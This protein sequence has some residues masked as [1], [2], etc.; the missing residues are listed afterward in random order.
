MNFHCIDIGNTSTS[1]CHVKNN[2][3]GKLTR[4]LNNENSIKYF[5][6]CK[7]RNID[8]VIISSV[9]PDISNQIIDDLE[10]RN[11]DY[12]NISYKNSVVEL[13]VDT[14]GEVGV[15]RLCNMAGTNLIVGYPSIIIDFGTATTYDVLDENC[16]FIGGAIAPGIDVSADN[17]IK[18]AALISKTAYKFP[19]SIIGKN[20]ISNIQSGVMY[21]GLNSVKGM[22][23]SISRELSYKKINIILTG[24]F[25]EL[26]SEKLDIRHAYNE[27]LTLIGML[28]IYKYNG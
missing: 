26:I 4:I 7:Y 19:D 12:F 23:T 22:I 16:K 3:L 1:L 21:G 27:K 13:A 18:K 5:L 6:D 25:G 24:G 10:S 9:V 14:P 20:T 28:E 17:L 2:V 8:K 15:D 11:I